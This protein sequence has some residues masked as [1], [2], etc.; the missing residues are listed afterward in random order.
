MDK[1]RRN[2]GAVVSTYR[3]TV[4]VSGI[5]PVKSQRSRHARHQSLLAP[6][7]YERRLCLVLIFFMTM[8][9]R[10]SNNNDPAGYN[11]HRGS[12][13]S[14]EYLAISPE[15]PLFDRSAANEFPYFFVQDVGPSFGGAAQQTGH[16]AVLPSPG[17]SSSTTYGQP[18]MVGTP[19]GFAVPREYTIKG[20]T[21]HMTPVLEDHHL[22]Q[23]LSHSVQSFS[24]SLSNDCTL[25]L[26]PQS[27]END[28]A[29]KRAAS[30]PGDVKKK[31]RRKTHNAIEKRYR[32]RL[33]DKITELRDSIPSL[34]TRSRENSGGET[35]PNTQKV[36][37]AN[38]L[39]KA[40]EYV[41]YLEESNRRLQ[42]QLHYA[43]Q[44]ANSRAAWEAPA[45]QRAK[46]TD[47]Q[48]SVSVPSLGR[49]RYTE[50]QAYSVHDLIPDDTATML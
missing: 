16:Y 33:N 28:D 36:N 44:R 23:D 4:L 9:Q 46:L 5:D 50:P 2:S 20:E 10:T 7:D 27:E 14:R 34:R 22:Q 1:A 49:D 11:E 19:P 24:P 15:Q 29:P 45:S 43:L 30:A 47:P 37:K 42:M 41:K 31:P 8:A 17:A 25:Q 6:G 26:S 32:T 35:D 18:S 39:E 38:I 48:G 13:A 3:P 40:T 21:G 12:A